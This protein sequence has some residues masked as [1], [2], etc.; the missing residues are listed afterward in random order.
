MFILKQ[1]IGSSGTRW[2][3]RH[4]ITERGD[5]LEM[6]IGETEPNLACGFDIPRTTEVGF[7]G[8]LKVGQGDYFLYGLTSS[9]VTTIVAESRSQ[10]LAVP[11]EVLPPEAHRP[12][13]RF[14]VLMREPVDDVEALVALDADRN[15]VQ[16]LELR[17]P[18]Q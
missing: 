18:S 13:L 7:S 12:S 5:C 8:G 15:I 16:R 1:G 9:R 6:A 4:S 3:L 14:F 2:E 11:T 17:G 10:D